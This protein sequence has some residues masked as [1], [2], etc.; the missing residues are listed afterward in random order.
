MG[1]RFAGTFPN[2]KLNE[3]PKTK[4][5]DLPR[6]TIGFGSRLRW[7]REQLGLNVIAFAEASE[8]AKSQVSRAER[9][10]PPFPSI[11]LV[12]LWADAAGVRPEWLLFG[13]EPMR[14]PV[15]RI[16]DRPTD[17]RHNPPNK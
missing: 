17:N 2:G 6:R 4:Q 10:E 3:V 15:V 14:D 11:Q 16:T 13:E 8:T 1:I 12:C 9:G 7:A 5:R